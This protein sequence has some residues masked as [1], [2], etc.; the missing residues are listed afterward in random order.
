MP[1]RAEVDARKGPAVVG[2]VCQARL[3]L[4][5]GLRPRPASWAPLA[6]LVR[7]IR[8]APPSVELGLGYGRGEARHG[9]PPRDPVRTS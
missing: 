9:R 2:S 8:L 5:L 7:A 6:S 4:Q 3:V 1:R